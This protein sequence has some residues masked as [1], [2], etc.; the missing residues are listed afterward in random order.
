MDHL[1][2]LSPG[3]SMGALA[4]I[5]GT[6]YIVRGWAETAHPL[7]WTRNGSRRSHPGRRVW[8]WWYVRDERICDHGKR[9]S[10]NTLA[11]A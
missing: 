8:F 5:R 2:P 6:V 11:G 7:G 4:S 1:L 3:S 10:L 9:G